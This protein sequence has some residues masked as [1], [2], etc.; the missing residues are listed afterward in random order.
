MKTIIKE[1]VLVIEIEQFWS[2][3]LWKWD[4]RDSIKQNKIVDYF[5]KT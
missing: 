3:R 4:I 5:A 2:F 1:E